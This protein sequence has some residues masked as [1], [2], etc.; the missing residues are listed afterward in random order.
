MPQTQLIPNE[1]STFRVLLDEQGCSNNVLAEFQAIIKNHYKVRGRKYP[2]REPAHYSDPYKV[3]VSEIMLQQTQADRVV[4]KYLAFIHQ[5]PDFATLARAATED[6]LKAWIGLGYNR[7]ALAL[8]KI[9]ETVI[10]QYG[11]KVPETIEALET[12]PS[13]GPNT[14]A[15]IATFA[16]NVA[17][18]FIETNIRA[19]YTFFFF[20]DQELPSDA[21]LLDIVEKTIDGSNPREWYYALMDYGVMLKK[22]GRDPTKKHQARPKQA[23]FKGSTR[24]MRGNILKLLLDSPRNA[25]ELAGDLGIEVVIVK[26]IAK[27]LETEGF[28]IEDGA[29]YKIK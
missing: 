6:V 15:S 26:R 21:V 2:F 17:V 16:F 19:V 4:E 18:P 3:V 25:E 28:L 23:S 10:E 13:V 29:M 20:Q 24:Q 9:A 1:V 22:E 5:F 7:R 27:Q 12:F 8:K 11:G 14:A